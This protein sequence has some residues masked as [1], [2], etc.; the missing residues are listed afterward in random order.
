[1]LTPSTDGTGSKKTFQVSANFWKDFLFQSEKNVR[2]GFMMSFYHQFENLVA[3]AYRLQK[4]QLALN[5][6]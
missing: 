2:N 4:K 1:M 6:K 3:I 5:N